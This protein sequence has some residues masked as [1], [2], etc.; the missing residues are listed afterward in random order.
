[1][2]KQKQYF[3]VNLK[4]GFGR[5][6]TESL[7]VLLEEKDTLILEGEIEDNLKLMNEHKVKLNE[8]FKLNFSE[9]I[10]LNNILK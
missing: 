1:M 6:S 7:K 4:S 10:G 3:V 5:I 9:L 8:S 2:M